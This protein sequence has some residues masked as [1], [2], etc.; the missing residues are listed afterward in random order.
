ML[1]RHDSRQAIRDDPDHPERPEAKAICRLLGWLPLALEL[2]GA[3]L[4]EWPDISLADYRKRLQEE[5]CLPTLDSEVDEP[6]RG[7][8]PADSR[9]RRRGHL[10]D[11]VGRPEAR[12]RDGPALLRVAGQ[13][14]EAAA[15]PTATL[16]LFAGVSQRRQ[17]RPSFSARGGP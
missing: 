14:A 3:F 11:P 1:L 13:F 16:G 6:R 5:G 8:L 7:Q 9:R 2:A 10:E 12:R 17:A 15:I 4:A